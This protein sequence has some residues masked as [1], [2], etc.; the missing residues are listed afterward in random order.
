MFQAEIYAHPHDIRL[1]YL[2]IYFK[3]RSDKYTVI[4]VEIF[5]FSFVG[6]N[7][8]F[9]ASYVSKLFYV[10]FNQLSLRKTYIIY[11]WHD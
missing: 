10:M 5:H 9:I 3:Y 6:T 11:F 1:F 4:I 2:F 8:N 7:I